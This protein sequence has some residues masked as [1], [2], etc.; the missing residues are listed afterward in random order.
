MGFNKTYPFQAYSLTSFAGNTIASLCMVPVLCSLLCLSLSVVYK[1]NTGV[2]KPYQSF[3]L[4]IPAL[5]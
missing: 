5:L 1:R 3:E 4:L 2:A